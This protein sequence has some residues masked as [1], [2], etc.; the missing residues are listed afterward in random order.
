[1]NA[2]AC[3]TNNDSIA[4]Y[5]DRPDKPWNAARI[6]H[7]Y[8]RIGFGANEQEIQAALTKTPTQLV[9][10]LIDGAIN[11]LQ[12]YDDLYEQISN[13]EG[14]IP[15]NFYVFSTCSTNLRNAIFEN[16]SIRARLVL[17]WSGHLVINAET[18][19]FPVWEYYYI[20]HEF[21]FGNFKEF[22]IKMGLSGAMLDF[23][24]AGHNT[25]DKP[26]QN[27]SRELLELFTMG[28]SDRYGNDNYDE[29]DLV[30]IAKVIT[31]WIRHA[32]LDRNLKFRPNCHD[33]TSK[34][35]MMT[36]QGNNGFTVS[37]T[38]TG[39]PP[40][41]S[42]SIYGD[43]SNFEF[44]GHPVSNPALPYMTA[45]YQELSLIHI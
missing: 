29:N 5:T 40:S 27:Y 18:R 38:L 17:F 19:G 42:C 43:D 24:S 26:N 14:E 1:M 2:I 10:E 36:T 6:R 15:G 25:V 23:L 31:G 13:N 44:E 4:A 7:L 37:P 39:A 11:S 20:L 34:T 30:E 28:I 12:S 9:D 22:I 3:N 45:A 21:A 41:G 8:N 33:W 32:D 16:D 35:I